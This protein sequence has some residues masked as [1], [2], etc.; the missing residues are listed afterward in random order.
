MINGQYSDWGQ[1]KAGV[2][3][4][5]VLGPLLFLLYINDIISCISHCK[6]RLFADDTCLFIEVDNRETAATLLSEDLSAIAEWAE[7]WLVT[8]SP[9]KTKS[10]TISNK[11]DA[12]L[13]PP[14]AF[15]GRLIDEVESHVSR[16]KI[17]SRFEVE[18]TY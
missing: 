15:M 2:L 16:V 12:Q 14:I 5:S 9:A 7:K 13:N 11:R 18:T 1:I 8:F 6:I 3:Q 17:F 4:G 10:L